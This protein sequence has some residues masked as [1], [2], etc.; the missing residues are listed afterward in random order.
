[1]PMTLDV[2]PGYP[3]A[4]I[5]DAVA[6]A[7]SGDEIVLHEASVIEGAVAI[8]AIDLTVRSATRTTWRAP[9]ADFL[10]LAV[11]ASVTL[12]WLDLRDGVTGVAGYGATLVVRDCTFANLVVGIAV[13]TATV[14]D[15]TFRDVGSALAG[16][17]LVVSDAVFDTVDMA[18]DDAVTA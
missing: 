13:S 16:G 8:P 12:E 11:G 6:A 2:G 5:A 17:D 14:S 7:F 18:I 1:G 10:D 4:S 9:G 15:A 3:Y